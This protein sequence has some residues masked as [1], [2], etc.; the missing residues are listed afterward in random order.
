MGKQW[1]YRTLLKKRP[2][3]LL[4]RGNGVR[5]WC[6]DVAR[7][8]LTEGTTMDMVMGVVDGRERNARDKSIRTR[9]TRARSHRALTRPRMPA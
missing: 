4:T 3:R 7:H 6:R 9:L 8:A 1:W 5:V 2:P